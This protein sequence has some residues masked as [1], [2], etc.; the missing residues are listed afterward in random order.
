MIYNPIYFDKY[1]IK[2]LGP[3]DD[4]IEVVS[5]NRCVNIGCGGLLVWENKSN[6]LILIDD[7]I[8]DEQVMM[9][10]VMC[11]K[12]YDKFVIFINNEGV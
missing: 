1:R 8:Q 11:N 6:F 10:L 3:N 12:C 9:N 2:V 7:V 4:R 5:G